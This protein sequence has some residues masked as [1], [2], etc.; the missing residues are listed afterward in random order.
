MGDTVLLH[1]SW[2]ITFQLAA[3]TLP[4]GSNLPLSRF[5][6]LGFSFIEFSG[7]GQIYQC[8]MF[9]QLPGD[10][11]P[12]PWLVS[13]KIEVRG[14][15]PD[16]S[17]ELFWEWAGVLTVCCPSSL[18]LHTWS[19]SDSLCH[20]VTARLRISKSPFWLP[21][22]KSFIVITHHPLEYG[23]YCLGLW[24]KLSLKWLYLKS[25]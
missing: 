18:K 10:I 22:W 17:P 21:F 2:V 4:P 15:V 19:A 3:P 7:V 8:A 1:M 11:Y 6:S 16:S 12:V 25:Y 9:P 5:P 20:H 14:L 24:L 23:I 13:L